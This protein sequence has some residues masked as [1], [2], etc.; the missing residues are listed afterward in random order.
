MRDIL[1]I[2]ALIGL[3]IGART[4]EEVAVPI[5]A[6]L[7]QSMRERA[8]ETDRRVAAGAAS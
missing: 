5:A 2:R 3:R 1:R 7:V 6:E 8:G 4:P